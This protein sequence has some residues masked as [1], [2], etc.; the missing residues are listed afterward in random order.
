[1]HQ[2]FRAVG[3]FGDFPAGGGEGVVVM[4]PGSGVVVPRMVADGDTGLLGMTG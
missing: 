2:V 3:R 4:A 1:M